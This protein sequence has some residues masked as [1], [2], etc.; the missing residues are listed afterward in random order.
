[1][2]LAAQAVRCSGD[3]SQGCPGFCEIET[4]SAEVPNKRLTAIYVPHIRLERQVQ[5]VSHN[6]H[7][8]D[9]SVNHAVRKH[10]PQVSCRQTELHAQHDDVQAEY[11]TENVAYDGEKRPD[12]G[13][14]PEVE[15]QAACSWD[16]DDA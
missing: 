11:E 3:G 5:Q 1:M 2:S 16:L 12:D 15:G 13:F 9:N 6:R 14:E 7:D 10:L 4:G 8:S